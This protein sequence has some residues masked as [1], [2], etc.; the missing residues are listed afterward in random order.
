MKAGEAGLVIF[1]GTL[2]EEAAGTMT[3][4]RMGGMRRIGGGRGG[5]GGGDEGPQIDTVGTFTIQAKNGVISSAVFNVTISGFMR[6]REFERTTTRTLTFAKVGKTEY[7]V[8]EEA[9][10]MFEI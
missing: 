8:P 9:L 2:T 5:G 1:T 10:A 7:E 4:R 6:D 3:G